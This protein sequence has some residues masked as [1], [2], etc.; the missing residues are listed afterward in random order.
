MVREKGNVLILSPDKVLIGRASI[1]RNKMEEFYQQGYSL[2][3]RKKKEIRE[4]IA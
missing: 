2:A 3:E 1:N 4:F